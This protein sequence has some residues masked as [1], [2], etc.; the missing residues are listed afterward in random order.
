MTY[1]R[2]WQSLTSVYDTGEAKAVARMV[3]D[4]RFGLSL[5]DILCGKDT[6]LSAKEQAEWQEI[7]RR[8]LKGEPVQYVLGVADFGPR[9]FAISPGVLIPRPETYELCQWCLPPSPSEWSGSVLDIGTG[10]GCIACT[11]AAELPKARVTGW[12]I[13]AKALDV[14]REN[15]KRAH[16]LVSFRCQDILNPP[17]DT[18]Q[19][20]LIVSNPP[21]ICERE[22][23]GMAP[24][25]LN[26]EPSL[27]LFVPDEDPL[28]FYQAIAEYARK[29]L[30]KGGKLYFEIN[31][32]YVFPLGEMLREQGFRDIL[33]GKDQFGKNR[34]VK[35]LWQ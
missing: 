34:F 8:L 16:V 13:S 24:W 5:A 26:H 18:A 25:V 7:L 32:L 9:Q 31:P 3:L 17:A 22:K 4:V 27:A 11:L 14:A 21:Y 28:L 6:Q 20:D 19:W 10:S 35:A 15:A 33:P 1:E 29:A 12:D 30:R 23:D 2:F